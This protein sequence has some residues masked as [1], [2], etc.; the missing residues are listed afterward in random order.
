L[1][2]VR[3]GVLEVET[4]DRRWAEALRDLLPELAGRLAAAYPELRIR[5]CRLYEGGQAEKKPPRLPLRAPEPDSGTT[6][7]GSARRRGVVVDAASSDVSASPEERR[8]RLVAVMK[9]YLER[10][11]EGVDS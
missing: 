10:T 5:A 7:A 3:R 6:P 2:G 8:E 9:R 1:R 11:G 4:T